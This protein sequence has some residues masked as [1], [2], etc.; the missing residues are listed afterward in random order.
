M[1]RTKKG[2][3]AP[4][5]SGPD[6][7]QPSKFDQETADKI[8]S[9]TAQGDTLDVILDV[10]KVDRAT[11]LH[12]RRNN[13]GFFNDYGN[14]K[15]EQMQAWSEQIISLMDNAITGPEVTVAL[16]DPDLERI[17]KDGK[18]TFKLHRTSIEH[19]RERIKVRQWLMERIDAESFGN[20]SSVTHH[21]QFNSMDDDQLNAALHEAAERA[22][23]SPEELAAMWKGEQVLQ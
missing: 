12:W 7:G 4:R 22:G 11:V 13:P 3:K 19:V 1:P 14:A 23:V 5:M 15:V 6:G 9:M 17:E 10:V 21:H 16:D 8:C 20:K 18:V 2:V